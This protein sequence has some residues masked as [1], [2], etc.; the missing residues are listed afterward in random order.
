MKE[1]FKLNRDQNLLAERIEFLKNI[2]IYSEEIIDIIQKMLSWDEFRR[3][4]FK[5]LL[6]KLRSTSFLEKNLSTNIFT[7]N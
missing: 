7:I 5:I 3:P 4:S 1:I 6:T 2:N